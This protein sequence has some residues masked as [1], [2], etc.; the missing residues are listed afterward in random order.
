[1]LTIDVLSLFVG[2]GLRNT[3][4]RFYAMSE[5]AQSKKNVVSTIFLM[6][7]CLNSLGVVICLFLSDHIS[8][9][10]FGSLQHS[11]HLRLV[12]L[13]FLFQGGIQIP[14]L[15]LRA[16]N[17][18]IYFVTVTG[19]KLVLLLSMNI[20]FVVFK[21]MGIT[22]ILYSSLTGTII[23]A[24]GLA[25]YTF[26]KVG[27]H[28]STEMCG[29]LIRYATPLVLANAGSFVITFSDRYFLKAYSSL[30]M[31]GI[32]S[33]A[34]K[35]AFVFWFLSSEPF[36]MV[37]GP[38]RFELAKRVDRD[39]LFNKVFFFCNILFISVAL[40][41]TFFVK[42][43]LVIMSDPSYLDAYK[44]VPILLVAYV[45]QGWLGLCNVGIF[46]A[47]KTKYAAFSDLIAVICIIILNFLLIPR[48][49]AYGAAFATA[50]AFFVRFIFSYGF[51]QRLL[52]INFLW[53]RLFCLLAIALAFYVSSVMIP[54]GFPIHLGLAV[55]ALLFLPFLAVIY[56]FLLSADE[57][58]EV[59]RLTSNGYQFLV[60][61]KF[62]FVSN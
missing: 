25:V 33:L 50:V 19:F 21:G 44:I 6:L 59:K 31:L 38:M 7:L 60:R 58:S 8:M 17:K 36:F 12:F 3:L 14:L 30:T 15:F 26:G 11:F 46:V 43:V 48:Y 49:H 39:Y 10:I 27:F 24:S 41:I 4:F 13:T 32:Y 20:Y 28:F 45:F 16:E 40:F 62:P 9:L 47:G 37:W 18:S 55:K 34:Y 54:D 5:G 1:M 51:S 53:N 52:Y 22:G 42:D 2:L 23:V 57:K 61:R 56:N 29:L 35:F